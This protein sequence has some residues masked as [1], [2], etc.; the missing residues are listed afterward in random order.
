[1][2]KPAR[3]VDLA[4]AE[5]A[6]ARERFMATLSDVRTRLQ[7]AQLRREAGGAIKQGGNRL[8][9]AALTTAQRHPARMAGLGVALMLLVARNQIFGVARAAG[10]RLANHRHA[11][12]KGAAND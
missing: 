12:P 9:R 8:A 11:P 3:D 5:A 1:M 6:A 10:A 4:K 7:P 2:S